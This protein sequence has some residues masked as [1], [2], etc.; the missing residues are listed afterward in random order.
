[1]VVFNPVIDY[2]IRSRSILLA[3]HIVY[4]S[5]ALYIRKCSHTDKA[6]GHLGALP[7]CS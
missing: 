3:H 7:T 4:Y 6:P 2:G 5:L 1:M